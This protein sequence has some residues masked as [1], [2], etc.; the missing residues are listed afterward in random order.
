MVSNSVCNT[1]NKT[2]KALFASCIASH[3][4]IH[5]LQNNASNVPLEWVQ[6]LALFCPFAPRPLSCPAIVFI[7]ANI[8]G[9]PCVS[10]M[11]L[12]CF[13]D[14]IGIQLHSDRVVL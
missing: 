2:A 12:V 9:V 1:K 5:I 6:V 8:A 14:G 10:A 4:F 13:E 7:T 11:G 3:A